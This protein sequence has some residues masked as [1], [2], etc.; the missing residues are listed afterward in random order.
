AAAYRFSADGGRDHARA[1]ACPGAG[2]GDAGNRNRL[3]PVGPVCAAAAPRAAAALGDSGRGAGARC[4]TAGG[5]RFAVLAAGPPPPAALATRV[6]T[7]SHAVMRIPDGTS[8]AAA[9]TI[10]V[11]FVTAIYALGT[12]GQLQAGEFV[13]IHAAAGGVGLAAIQ[14]AKLRGATVI[15]TA[16]S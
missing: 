2:G 12:L 7:A 10:P 11:T 4:R 13:L 1:G 5:H 15:A 6:T 16:G 9:A 3:D 8:F 14:Y